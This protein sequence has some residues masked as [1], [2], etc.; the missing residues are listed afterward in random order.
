M[1]NN[2]LDVVLYDVTTFYFDSEVKKDRTLRQES[3]SKDVKISKSQILFILLFDNHKQPI[4]YRIY[5]DNFF[6]GQTFEQ[7]ILQLK[8]QY[9]IKNIV[10]VADRVLLNRNNISQPCVNCR[11]RSVKQSVKVNKNAET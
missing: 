10:I 1:F 8:Q 4:G 9:Q 2:T 11:L 3:F 6:E 5:K 7:D